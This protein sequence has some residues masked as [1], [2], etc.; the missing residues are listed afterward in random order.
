MWFT[1]KTVC[2]NYKI[3]ST[4]RWFKIIYTN[5]SYIKVVRFGGIGVSKKG[6]KIECKNVS[7][8]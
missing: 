6:L 8:G 3:S 4:V 5:Y 1:N 7:K 2:T